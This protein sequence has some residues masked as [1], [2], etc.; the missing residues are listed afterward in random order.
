MPMKHHDFTDFPISNI[1][2]LPQHHYLP[3]AL[4]NEQAKKCEIC[5]KLYSFCGSTFFLQKG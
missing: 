2:A 4:I 3:Q 5:K 1:G